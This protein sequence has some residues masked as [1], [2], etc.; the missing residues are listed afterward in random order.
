MCQDAGILRIVV[1]LQSKCFVI[2]SADEAPGALFHNA[3]LFN[4]S[5]W[6]NCVWTVVGNVIFVRTIVDVKNGEE[7]FISYTDVTLPWPIRSNNNSYF[8]FS[9]RCPR[10]R[11]E[12][13]SDAAHALAV[14][15]ADEAIA[16]ARKLR[17]DV[18]LETATHTLEKPQSQSHDLPS[19]LG[20]RGTTIDSL[21]LLFVCLIDQK[22]FEDAYSVASKVLELYRPFRGY[23]LEY[24]TWM[25]KVNP[26]KL[27]GDCAMPQMI[28]YMHELRD[29]SSILHG[30]GRNI[31]S[32]ST[33]GTLASVI[34]QTLRVWGSIHFRPCFAW[35]REREN[36]KAAKA[37]E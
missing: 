2:D 20:I 11:E 14:P 24:L 1:N 31:L 13:E 32:S 5:C 7:C 26:A 29:V 30:G 16:Y 35:K 22:R 4:Y 19:A 21:Q 15:V 8:G 3:S 28:Q 36:L 33:G 18:G 34:S 6:P 27:L 23:A 37:F 12:S 9:C 10:F 25:V 17:N